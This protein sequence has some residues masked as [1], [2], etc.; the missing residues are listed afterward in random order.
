MQ[1]SPDP[2]PPDPQLNRTEYGW[3]V[4]E[5]HS[6]GVF[7]L[8][9][10]RNTAE[11]KNSLVSFFR[12]VKEL[13]IKRVVMDVRQNLGGDSSVV[14]QFFSF[15]PV[16]LGGWFYNTEE[17]KVKR[18]LG[19]IRYSP[20]A[21]Q[22]CGYSQTNGYYRIDPALR[23]QGAPMTV[24]FPPDPELI[25]YG[26]VFIFTANRT[27]SSANWFAVLVQDN[28]LGFVLGEPTGNRPSHFGYPLN[29][30]IPYSKFFLSISHIIWYRPDYTKDAED[31]LY[32]DYYFPTTVQHIREGRDAQLEGL[33]SLFPDSSNSHRLEGGSK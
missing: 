14:N 23:I 18:F 22:Q 9:I 29:F 13:G 16:R 12:R 10:C 7:Y 8:D 6:L 31:A 25:F 4:D 32:P 20:E 17:S 19:D 5:A 1:L 26:N 28:K 15:L 2:P 11:Y 21:S 3:Q 24:L 33:L 27:N 30:E